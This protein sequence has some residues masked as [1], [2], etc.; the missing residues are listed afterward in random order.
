[1]LDPASWLDAAQTLTLGQR[2][3]TGHDCG[4][5]PVLVIEHK[6]N[7]WSAWC[8]RCHDK[9]W[10]PK[11]APTL[12][13][14]YAAKAAQREADAAIRQDPR[15]PY[16]PTFDVAQ[17]P[18][19]ARVWLYKAGLN[20]EAIG[21][22]GAYFHEP[23]RRV[24]LPV[25][26]EGRL[27][28]WQA[29][30]VG[31]CEAGAPKYLN[32]HVDRQQLC[33]RF[34][35]DDVVVLVEDILSAYRVGQVGE[36]WSLMGTALYT[37]TLVR[38]LETGKPVLVWLDND[39]TIRNA[40]QRAAAEV[41]RTLTNVGIKCHNIVS[42]RDPKLHSRDE[43]RRIIHELRPFVASDHEASSALQEVVASG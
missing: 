17:W 9:G 5:G 6:E 29:R 31:L 13:E 11:P 28:Y 27:V 34:G 8:H 15:P 38:L 23:S 32:P 43:I 22:L 25:L 2:R 30:N 35:A 39:P 40:G 33:P 36:A 26:D 41:M 42:D 16:P 20:N 7:G 4:D 14:R 24:V 1:M 21:Q 19:Q 12:A 10:V 37:P 18:L 3:R